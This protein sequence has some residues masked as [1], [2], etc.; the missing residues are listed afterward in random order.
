[1][2]GR[3]ALAV[4]A[5]G[6][7]APPLP[8]AE[9]APPAEGTGNGSP[10]SEECETAPPQAPTA[11]PMT[12]PNDTLHPNMAPTTYRDSAPAHARFVVLLGKSRE[13]R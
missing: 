5:I 1:V 7:G 10:S 6:I 11:R 8:D 4:P 3:P 13:R 9:E 12:T 2:L